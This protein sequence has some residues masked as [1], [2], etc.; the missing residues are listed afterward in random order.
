MTC[1]P[2]LPVEWTQ[3]HVMDNGRIWCDPIPVC[4]H[5]PSDDLSVGVLRL[6]AGI[7]RWEHAVGCPDLARRLDTRADWAL[8]EF[9]AIADEDWRSLMIGWAS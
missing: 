6:R 2:M 8:H 1:H 4:E 5:L 3:D 7:D 9:A